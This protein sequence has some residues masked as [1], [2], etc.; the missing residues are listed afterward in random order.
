MEK[1]V[2]KWLLRL[3]I[4]WWKKIPYAFCP[5]NALFLHE[6]YTLFMQTKMWGKQVSRF[7]I[8]S[9]KARRVGILVFWLA[10][11]G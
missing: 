3:F 6:L 7:L 10:S 5:R 4:G 9:Y 11:R 8:L 1:F 2:L